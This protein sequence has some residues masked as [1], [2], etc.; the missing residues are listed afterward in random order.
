MELA[1]ALGAARRNQGAPLASVRA[2]YAALERPLPPHMSALADASPTRIYLGHEFCEH[3]LPRPL[4][5]RESLARARKTGLAVSFATPVASDA[6]IARLRRLFRLLPGGCEVVCNDWGV[7]AL[8]HREFPQ[9]VVVAGRQLCRMI[10]DPRLPSA[11][12]A[13]LYPHGMASPAFALLLDRCGVQSIELDV[14]PF[15]EPELFEALP[16]PAAVHAPYGYAAKGRVCRIGSLA[17]RE[18]LRFSPGHACRRECLDYRVGVARAVGSTD[19]ATAQA[20]NT[21]HYAHSEAMSAVLGEAIARGR[22]ARLVL[23]AI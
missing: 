9:L 11:Q 22:V 2:H 8:A 17:Q 10:K 15:A 23:G 12:W 14:P 16:R 18:P 19:L 1:M 7:A 20:G 13:R 21:L 6:C 4:E 3:L 5:L